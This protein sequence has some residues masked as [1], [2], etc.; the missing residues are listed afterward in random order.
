MRTVDQLDA[1]LLTVLEVPI[2]VADSLLS[3]GFHIISM[4]SAMLGAGPRHGSPLLSKQPQ[5]HPISCRTFSLCA[6]SWA[7]AAA[8]VSLRPCRCQGLRPVAI[9][10]WL[11][12][13]PGQTAEKRQTASRTAVCSAFSDAAGQYLDSTSPAS[14]DARKASN[15]SASTSAS[16]PETAA[17]NSKS[18]A[19]PLRQAVLMLRN[20]LL[21]IFQG[22]AAFFKAFPAFVR[23][24]KLQ[25]LH[26]R[27]L[28]DP[29][30]ADK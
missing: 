1:C 18:P 16:Q 5:Q 17:D 25:H 11:T 4:Q 26:K 2:T 28:D 29:T 9:P 27:A 23:R 22:I 8:P 19:S 30:N 12:Y 7:R 13:P 14:D 3:A 20:K 24:E 6:Y 21:A 10:V 15:A